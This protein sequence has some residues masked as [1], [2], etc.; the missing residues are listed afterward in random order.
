MSDAL[1]IQT[2]APEDHDE[3][4]RW[5][6]FI[7][8]EVEA[9]LF[10]TLPWMDMVRGCFPHRP[11]YLMACREETIS[12]VLPLFEVRS[13][14][15]GTIL[16]SVPYGVYG[17]AVTRE[18]RAAAALL[19][20]TR[21]L[22]RRLRVRFVDI[23]SRRAMWPELPTLERY[24]TFVKALPSSADQVVAGFPRKARAEVRRARDTFGLQVR[25]HDD[26]LPVVWQLYSQS[27]RRLGSPNLPWRFFQAAVQATPDHH[28]VSVVYHHHRP[29]AG[30]L[31][32]LHRD[33]VLP[34]YSGSDAEV[35]GRM[36]A[37]NY[38]Y[39]TLMEEA[40]RRGAR[41]FDF[42]R[43]RLDNPGSFGF[44]KNQG[45]V[46]APLGYQYDV[47]DGGAVPNLTPGNRRFRLAQAVWKRL[48]LSLTRPLGS[49]LSTAIP[50]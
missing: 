21:D 44:K 31:S 13:L 2:L 15:A 46:P 36:G 29:I 32:F 16:V 47:A 1:R 48:P 4:R 41:N 28:V 9:T 7:D 34:Y 20:A 37:N 43:S 49:W 6:Q 33:T 25:F 12:G 39:A 14:L 22:A 42:G 3:R 18:P 5:Q 26:Q 23:R 45:F 19:T 10:H 8:S 40:V 24:V 27:M 17:G 38:L 50:G 35:A 11:H 30:L